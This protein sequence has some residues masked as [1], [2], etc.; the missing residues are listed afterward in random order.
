MHQRY[1]DAMAV[2]RSLGKPDLF[3]TM[4]CN[5]KCPEIQDNLKP[6][7]QA[8]DRPDLVTRVF[9]MKLDQLIHE[10]TK[11]HVLGRVI[12][13]LHVIEFQKRGLPQTHL[14]IILAPE[15][16]LRTPEDYDRYALM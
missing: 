3:V 12:D 15:D 7:Q 13:K 4:T 5:P 2:V 9:R 10:I 11:E 14:L 6:G 1:Q 16:K 8:V